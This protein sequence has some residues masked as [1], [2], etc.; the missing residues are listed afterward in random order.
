M[1]LCLDCMLGKLEV[2]SSACNVGSLLDSYDIHIQGKERLL[3]AIDHTTFTLPD[4]L[5]MIKE[6]LIC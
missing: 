1:V 3:S 2:A 5:I 4:V 6:I